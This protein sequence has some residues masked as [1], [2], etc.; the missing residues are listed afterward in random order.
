MD[1]TAAATPQWPLHDPQDLWHKIRRCSMHGIV[2][3]TAVLRGRQLRWFGHVERASSGTKSGINLAIRNSRRRD[4]VWIFHSF[5]F[6]LPQWYG[7]YLYLKNFGIV[8][9]VVVIIIITIDNNNN[10]NSNN[11]I[12]T[13]S[14]A[15]LVHSGWELSNRY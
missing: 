7:K 11:I 12:V 2:D 1:Q 14:C 3:I 8:V 13:S 5:H 15:N 9:I 10:H 6:P 4:L